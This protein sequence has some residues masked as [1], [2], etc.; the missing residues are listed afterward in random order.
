MN[1]G[2]SGV[3]KRLCWCPH[4]PP[5]I[6]CSARVSSAPEDGCPLVAVGSVLIVLPT[7]FHRIGVRTLPAA[8][9]PLPSGGTANGL[10]DRESVCVRCS[11]CVNDLCE[12]IMFRC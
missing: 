2:W 8:S 7:P 3:E 5:G 10:A 9:S 12:N 11:C 4:M 1:I 6:T